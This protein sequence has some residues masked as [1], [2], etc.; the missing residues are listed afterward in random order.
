MERWGDNL[1]LTWSLDFTP[2]HDLQRPKQLS[3]CTISPT[4][5][6][7]M[8]GEA[9]IVRERSGNLLIGQL[10]RLGMPMPARQPST[11]SIAQPVD[12]GN[13]QPQRPGQHQDPV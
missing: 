2:G 9:G 12:G 4:H 13:G 7:T 5:G 6:N 11:Q 8:P 10:W 1:F 3:K